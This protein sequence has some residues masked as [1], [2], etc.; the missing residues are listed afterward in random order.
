VIIILR[1]M[2]R[3]LGLFLYTAVNAYN[4]FLTTK[5]K[6]QQQTN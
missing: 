5:Q 3:L 6:Q 4:E 2:I 1:C